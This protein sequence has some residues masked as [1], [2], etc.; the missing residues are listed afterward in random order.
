MRLTDTIQTPNTLL[1]QIR[2]EWQVKHYH[3]AG[4]LEVTSFR[5]DFRAQQYLR[6]GVFFGKPGGS[7]VT[8]DNRHTFVEY[9]GAN[10]FTFAQYLLQ[11]QRSGSFGA[12]HQHFLR[13]MAGQV[14]HQ[15]L[16]ARIEV[17]PGGVITFKFL[18]NTLRVEHIA[19]AIF[20][21][22]RAPIMPETLIAV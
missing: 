18:I 9:R 14:A 12:D 7:A 3:V 19:S 16:N 11:L 6:A 21:T 10:T 5:T 15:P 22:L 13:A 17:P 2:V 20:R 8:F 4:E 1:Q